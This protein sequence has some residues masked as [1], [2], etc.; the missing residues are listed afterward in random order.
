[1]WLNS[2]W[3]S[4]CEHQDQGEGNADFHPDFNE[5]YNKSDDIGIPS[6]DENYIHKLNPVKTAKNSI[7]NYFDCHLQTN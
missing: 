5:I 7:T 3:Y 6:V 4:E 2:I 1:M